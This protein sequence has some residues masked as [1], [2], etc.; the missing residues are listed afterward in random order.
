MNWIKNACRDLRYACRTLTRSR[1]F[2]AT[3][4]AVLALGIGASTTVYTVVRGIALRPLPF[5]EPNRLMFIGELSPAGR[6]EA[7][8]PANVAN[9]ASQSRAFERIALYRGA[10]F[11]L[12]GGPVPES[13]IGANISSTFFAALRIQPQRGRT[14]LPE[15]EQPGGARPVML[16]DAVWT[17]QFARDPAIVG[18]TITLD[19]LDHTIVG[20][21][22]SA[23]SLFDTDF[24][25][26]GFDPALLNSRVAH[27]MGAM[28]RLAAGVTP[29][30]ARAELETIGG[31]LASA[32]PDTNAG[33]T[34]RMMPL[35][36]AWLGVYRSPSLFLL[37]AVGLVL[38]I[39]CAN[40][41]GLLLERA[42]SRER[43]ILIC[44]ALGARRGRIVQ[45]M[46]TESLLL[47][48]LGGVA[49]VVAA[50]WSIAFVVR[51]IPANTLTQI[52]NGAGAIHLDLRAL[53]V[54]LVVSVAAGKIGRAHV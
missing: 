51:L 14:F 13:V 11:I 44:L 28:G 3:A 4:L 33:W 34:F 12:T 36:E 2:T 46:L 39:A 30:H 15:D 22:P 53:A 10:R 20:V 21:L 42:L 35:Q 18:R 50:S 19:G 1:G 26:A 49:G 25:V 8:A 27:N 23:F 47:A 52:P 9:L 16:S 38:L 37:A 7:A 48:L 54:A 5:D 6:R 17:R 40:L 41:A 24:W 43:E 31:R 45:Q 32:Y 29:D